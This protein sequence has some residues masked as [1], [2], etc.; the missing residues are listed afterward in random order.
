MKV[1]LV[2][3]ARNA[4]RTIA[5]TI[6]SAL[7]QKGVDLEYIVIDGA[8]DDGTHA[9]V[10]EARGLAGPRLPLPVRAR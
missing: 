3:A 7:S 5:A 9:R 1:S 6:E 4:E 2:T 8:S 10:R